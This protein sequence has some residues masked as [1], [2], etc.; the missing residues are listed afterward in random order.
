MGLFVRNS[1]ILLTL[2][3]LVQRSG[4][5]VT[6]DWTAATGGSYTNA[7]N[8]D[9]F[10]IPNDTTE[11]ARFDNPGDFDITLPAGVTTN[12]DNFLVDDGNVRFASDGVT[13]ATYST[14]GDVIFGGGD[15]TLTRVAGAGD[16]HLNVANLL[17]VIRG[18]T[19]R[20]E[21]GATVTTRRFFV[22]AGSGHGTAIFDGPGSVLAVTEL[23]IGIGSFG[24]T[25]TLTFQNGSIGNSVVGITQLVNASGPA[26]SRGRLNVLSG[27]SLELEDILVGNSASSS[28]VQEAT[29][30]VSGSGSMLTQ[31]GTSTLTIGDD[32]NPNVAS[33]VIISSGGT[34]NSGAGAILIRNSGTLTVTD[35]TFNANGPMTMTA[36]TLLTLDG[37]ALNINDGLDNS[38]DGT[39]DFR[40]GT[41]TVTGGLFEPK[42]EGSSTSSTVLAIDGPTAVESPHLVFDSLGSMD[43]FGIMK[44][45]ES[46]RGELTVSGG[47]DIAPRFSSIGDASGASGMATVVGAGSTWATS[48]L[49][50]GNFGT[51]T[52]HVLDGG[53]VTGNISVGNEA[54]SDGQ[55]IVDGAGS[56][57]STV[58]GLEVGQDGKGVVHIQ[59]GARVVSRFAR[60]GVDFSD[61]GTGA[62]GEVIVDG[63]GSHWDS[64]QLDVAF[65]GVGNIEIR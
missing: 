14:A 48:S 6:I 10:D 18:S 63:P 26:E 51:G 25:G 12:V 22:G 38:A 35:G 28:N 57:L 2:G 24:T 19:L 60:L 41:L 46:N 53:S 21:L 40:D 42:M 43:L 55:V 37:G 52:L 49:V 17:Q 11:S 1:L 33:D 34:F 15:L 31:T 16:A 56:R 54:G 61:L 64:G 27:S 13:A 8:W 4:A 47:A 29:L 45:G 23:G 58:N 65:H 30:S 32:V 36:G 44:V 7:A 3:A 50:V 9:G 59:N 20:A 39:I 5:Q 62:D